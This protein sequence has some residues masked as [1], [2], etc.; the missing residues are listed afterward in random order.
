M[1]RITEKILLII[2]K[3]PSKCPGLFFPHNF[4]EIEGAFIN[5]NSLAKLSWGIKA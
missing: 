5:F 2:V 4:F 3:T 1:G